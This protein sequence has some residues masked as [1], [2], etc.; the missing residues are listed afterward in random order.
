MKIKIAC[1]YRHLKPG[2]KIPSR[3]TE[4]M[5]NLLLEDIIKIEVLGEKL[6]KLGVKD[7]TQ[8]KPGKQEELYKQFLSLLSFEAPEIIRSLKPGWM[9]T[10]KQYIENDRKMLKP[11]VSS[12]QEIEM[13]SESKPFFSLIKPIH[14]L[15][16]FQSEWERYQMTLKKYGQNF[17]HSY[18]SNLISQR[19]LRYRIPSNYFPS[20]VEIGQRKSKIQR[21]EPC[22]IFEAQ[23]FK[24]KDKESSRKG[25]RVLIGVFLPE[26]GIDIYA[27]IFFLNTATYQK[28]FNENHLP[29]QLC[30]I[31]TD[32]H[33]DEESRFM[34]Q[35]A[36]LLYQFRNNIFIR[37]WDEVLKNIETDNIH[38][39][40]MEDL[41][42]YQE[43]LKALPENIIRQ[44][45]RLYPQIL[46]KSNWRII[47]RCLPQLTEILF[48]QIDTNNLE[49]WSNDVYQGLISIFPEEP[50][51]E[52]FPPLLQT[53]E[54]LGLSSYSPINLVKSII[55][56]VSDMPHDPFSKSEIFKMTASMLKTGHFNLKSFIDE[57][58]RMVN[59][60]NN[61]G[62]L[63]EA[64]LHLSPLI[65]L[66]SEEKLNRSRGVWIRGEQLPIE[67]APEDKVALNPLFQVIGDIITTQVPVC[68]PG[69]WQTANQLEQFL[70]LL[71]AFLDM[72]AKTAPS[73]KTGFDK[74][75]LDFLRLPLP[76]LMDSNPCRYPSSFW[77]LLKTWFQGDDPLQSTLLIHNYQEE[78][79]LWYFNMS[80]ENKIDKL[81][82]T[83]LVTWIGKIKSD[84]MANPVIVENFMEYLRKYEYKQEIWTKG[85]NFIR[86]AICNAYSRESKERIKL[87]R[88]DETF[89]L[90]P[91]HSL[92]INEWR[93]WVIKTLTLSEYHWKDHLDSLLIKGF[94]WDQNHGDSWLQILIRT[95][96][97]NISPLIWDKCLEEYEIRCI[98]EDS[99]SL[100]NHL[101]KLKQLSKCNIQR[102]D[103]LSPFSTCAKWLESLHESIN[104]NGWDINEKEIF[105]LYAGALRS[106][107]SDVLFSRL[108]KDWPR[109][110]INL[111]KKNQV[112]SLNT[113]VQFCQSAHF[114]SDMTRSLLSTELLKEIKGKDNLYMIHLLSKSFYNAGIQKIW[115]Q[116]FKVPLIQGEMLLLVEKLFC[117]R[118][119][120]SILEFQN[121]AWS[122]ADKYR[123]Q[124]TDIAR[125]LA[126]LVL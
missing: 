93:D 83:N 11:A 113:F 8:L 100:Q 49:K 24:Y 10:L 55:N 1:L 73:L 75:K 40:F 42:T 52:D 98:N 92:L 117:S 59:H 108:Q 76:H 104:G 33:G 94:L 116:I 46:Q 126:D 27:S 71:D 119:E 18:L 31:L 57:V 115:E 79:I 7:K 16:G 80:M 81:Q 105:L 96:E 84:I 17:S 13:T 109:I 106:E 107:K 12:I 28:L 53:I 41:I 21:T 118:E 54:N 99:F 35:I 5:I 60:C 78:I 6:Y 38:N 61:N 65:E 85:M 15:M 62:R 64:L 44:L 56:F 4:E 23:K 122:L 20:K 88:L 67:L 111:L 90:E 45:Q 82:L 101:E 36:S 70:D 124:N 125:Q 110:P 39:I 58:I 86:D 32:T 121:L 3:L 91:W 123:N 50:T 47:K 72:S 95:S 69:V 87:E 103:D 48:S 22:A 112:V 34:A 30:Q 29:N 14:S 68:D 89:K 25:I 43:N 97:K 37:P 77:P 74:D 114:L 19:T 120:R 2:E 26:Q 51:I 66:I 102:T 9:E 63:R